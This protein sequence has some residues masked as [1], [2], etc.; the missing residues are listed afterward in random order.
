MSNKNDN[1]SAAQD[2]ASSSR[3]RLLKGVGLLGG[4]FALGGAAGAQAEK[5]PGAKEEYT[6]EPFPMNAGASNPITVNI[7]PVF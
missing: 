3:R 7:R 1:K 6:P 4:A 2:V 5:T